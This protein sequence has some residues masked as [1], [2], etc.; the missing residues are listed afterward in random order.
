MIRTGI[1]GDLGVL[2][3]DKEIS[4]FRVWDSDLGVK[5]KYQGSESLGVL[6]SRGSGVSE[7][8]G[9]QEVGREILWSRDIGVQ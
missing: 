6:R 3:G 5:G 1:R 7:D 9:V 4:G 2:E 8:L